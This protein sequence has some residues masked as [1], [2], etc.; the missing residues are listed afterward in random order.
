MCIRDSTN[1]MTDKAIGSVHYI[2]P[3]QVS[4]DRIDQRSDIYSVGV[5]LY[6][7]LTG[8]LP[9]DADN[10]VSVALMQLQLD[11]PSPRTKNPEIPEGLEQIIL[12]L[13]YTSYFQNAHPKAAKAGRRPACVPAGRRLTFT[14]E[15]RPLSR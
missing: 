6:E 1:T 3:E 7:M 5:T 12:C 9:F 13:L 10:P 8:E 15:R 14:F 2:S 4:A 11:P